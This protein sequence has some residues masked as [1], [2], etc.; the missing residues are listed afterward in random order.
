[1]KWDVMAISNETA[2]KLIQGKFKL[3]DDLKNEADNDV[4]S[5][6][7]KNE[8]LYRKIKNKNRDEFVYVIETI[9]INE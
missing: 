6:N 1:M 5:Y 2:N 8:I 4:S 7:K 3:F 9:F